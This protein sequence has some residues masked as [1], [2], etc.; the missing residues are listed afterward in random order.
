MKAE[1]FSTAPIICIDAPPPPK[2]SPSARPLSYDS[3]YF[4][5]QEARKALWP[6]RCDG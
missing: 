2:V 6:F 4:T 1:V 3:L 5:G